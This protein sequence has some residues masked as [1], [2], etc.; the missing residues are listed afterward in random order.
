MPTSILCIVTYQ[1]GLKIALICAFTDLFG[2]MLHVETKVQ[3]FGISTLCSIRYPWARY[4]TLA[5]QAAYC[6]VLEVFSGKVVNPAL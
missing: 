6:A 2:G 1:N 3:R 5:L 4:E